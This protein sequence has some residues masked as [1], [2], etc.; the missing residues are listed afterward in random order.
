MGILIR[1][2]AFQVDTLNNIHNITK[3]SIHKGENELP[4]P[5]RRDLDDQFLFRSIKR[6]YT[7]KYTVSDDPIPIGTITKW[8]E[9]VGKLAAF[10]NTTINYSLRYMAGNNLDQN[11]KCPYH[12]IG[13][14]RLIIHTV[15]ISDA[16]RNLVMGHAPNSDTFQRHY[17]NRIVC[18]DLWAIHRELEPQQDLIRKVASHGHSKSSRR[19]V[20]LTSAQSAALK[21]D[22]KVVRLTRQRDACRKGDP[23]RKTISLEIK[24]RLAKLYS[25]EL[26][27]VR[28]EWSD[29]QAI[30]D[31][32]NQIEG[33]ETV[34][35]TSPAA[36]ATDMHPIQARMIDALKETV[37]TD[38]EQQLQRR[39]NA[40]NMIARYCLVQVCG[41]ES[42]V[43]SPAPAPAPA[44][45]QL[46]A[47]DRVEELRQSVQ[48]EPGK[49]I[50]RCFVCVGNA[51]LLSPDDP[52]YAKFCRNYYSPRDAAKHFMRTHLQH[53]K[54]DDRL[55][56]PVCRPTVWL[57]HKKHFQ[58]HAELVH[59]L[60]SQIKYSYSH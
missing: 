7:G 41:R 26:S 35:E 9:R 51:L 36:G 20:Q 47:E 16:L 56:C 33:K 6:D 4:L 30:Q 58:N 3:L 32:T 45:L 57:Q 52:W 1:H 40:I 11:G 2:R 14:H 46:P 15:N 44:E 39:T 19:P 5:L 37:V 23:K 54:D 60:R 31:I 25:E 18:A 55:R 28:R 22:Q 34:E 17:L 10:E 38:I 24:A 53:L 48:V 29:T 59:G 21:R 49:K 43:V 27:K 8:V 13:N 42:K 12:I 50:S